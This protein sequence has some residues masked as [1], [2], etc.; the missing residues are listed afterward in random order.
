MENKTDFYGIVNL[1]SP[2]VLPTKYSDLKKTGR[3]KWIKFGNDN[4]FPQAIA[5]I[6]R[7]SPVHRGIINNKVTYTL[8]NGIRLNDKPITLLNSKG[9]DLDIIA[10]RIILDYYS[11]GNAWIEVITDSRRT[12][13]SLYHIDSTTVRIS[14]E[15]DSVWIHPRWSEYNSTKDKLRNIVLYP[16]FEPVLNYEGEKTTKDK[17]LHSIVHISTYEPEFYYYGVPQWIAA[18]NAATIAY[19]TDKWNLSR[20]DNSFLSSGVLNIVAPGASTEEIA[21]MKKEFEKTMTGEGNQGKVFVMITEP[22]EGNNTTYTPISSPS[23]AD[24]IQMTNQTVDTLITAHNW[25]RSLSG[26]SDNTGFDTKRILQ[27]YEVANNTII[28][29]TQNLILNTFENILRLDG[30]EFKQ[31]QPVSLF[32]L[33]DANKFITIGEARRLAGLDE[34]EDENINKKFVSDGT[35][36]STTGN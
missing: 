11:F 34:L 32:G 5:Q 8:G 24:W 26:I 18:M 14:K 9:H 23:E 35:N 31:K 20:L 19:K 28:N 21:Q 6:N 2:I 15:K 16:K 25:Y 13:T 3:D 7:S 17:Y 27:E 1:T 10:K 12:F 33:L 29:E 22:G 4:L 30:L 36:N